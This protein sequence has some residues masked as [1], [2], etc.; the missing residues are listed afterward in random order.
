MFLIPMVDQMSFASS[1]TW[2]KESRWAL[3][4]DWGV[5]LRMVSVMSVIS[6]PLMLIARLAAGISLPT[7]LLNILSLILVLLVFI[8]PGIFLFKWFVSYAPSKWLRRW[9]TLG[10]Y[11]VLLA[12]AIGAHGYFSS[13]RDYIV[14]QP[15]P[16]VLWVSLVAS[17]L[18]GFSLA[19]YCYFYFLHRKEATAAQARFLAMEQIGREAEIERLRAQI[20]PHFLFNTLTSI[21]GT[22]TEPHVEEM[23]QRLADV[24]RYNL[25]HAGERARFEEEVKAIESYLQLERM[26]FG[27]RLQYEVEVSRVAR[28][29]MVSQPV[30]LPL[31]ENAIKHGFMTSPRALRLKVEVGVVGAELRAVVEN[32]GRWIEPI[33]PAAP[34]TQI[35]L[36]NLKRR[37]ALIYGERARVDQVMLPDAV[38]F[39]ITLPLDVVA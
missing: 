1:M 17:R 19:I 39:M 36:Y 30:L 31:V 4:I 13:T 22:T 3:K 21:A 38:R 29:A 37:L 18:V 14:Q 2:I 8:V 25:S 7:T 20:N 33:V 35:G 5:F 32:S 12:I 15:N 11:I 26:R 34:G 6:V 10:L 27:D 28:E 24:L 16:L 9:V 23:T